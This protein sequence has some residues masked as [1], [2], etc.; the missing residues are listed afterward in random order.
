MNDKT[1]CPNGMNN[2]AASNKAAFGNKPAAGA[3]SQAA[4]PMSNQTEM[5]SKGK[6]TG[7]CGGGG[8]GS[9]ISSCK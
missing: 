7:G 9:K 4:K 5:G 6:S 8:C 1:S 3:A 2:Q